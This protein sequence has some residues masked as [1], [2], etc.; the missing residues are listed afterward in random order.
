MYVRPTDRASGLGVAPLALAPCPRH[1][2]SA[3][4]DVLL[5]SGGG[6]GGHAAAG[7]CQE[8]RG[9]GSTVDVRRPQLGLCAGSPE[10]A[11]TW[12]SM[13]RVY[14]AQGQL[15]QALELLRL[16]GDDQDV[17]SDSSVGWDSDSLY[18]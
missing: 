15:D 18:D 9:A 13:A 8:L 4:A 3:A 6:C 12:R 17:S 11:T 14:E 1:R 10:L 16:C 7:T 5:S 2:S